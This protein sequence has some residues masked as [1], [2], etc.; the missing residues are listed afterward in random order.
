MTGII[1][2]F[3]TMTNGKRALIAG[4]LLTTGG[5]L[6]AF[7]LGV[8]GAAPVA[9][10]YGAVALSVSAALLAVMGGWST[11]WGARA[12]SAACIVGVVLSIAAFGIVLF[13]G[14]NEAQREADLKI[15]DDATRGD[16]S[17]NEVA[18]AR[19]R[20]LG[21][22]NAEVIL[23]SATDIARIDAALALATE[24]NNSATTD[25]NAKKVRAAAIAR[26]TADAEFA[27]KGW[28]GMVKDYLG[29]G[30]VKEKVEGLSARLSC[31]VKLDGWV[32][33][34]LVVLYI[35]GFFAGVVISWKPVVVE[36]IRIFTSGRDTQ[37]NQ[38]STFRSWMVPVGKIGLT[39]IM[40]LIVI[41]GPMYLFRNADECKAAI[42]DGLSAEAIDHLS[43][44]QEKARAARERIAERHAT[45]QQTTR[46]NKGEGQRK[47]A[48]VHETQIEGTVESA[49][50]P[51][52]CYAFGRGEDGNDLCVNLPKNEGLL[53][54]R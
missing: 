4:G 16:V 51:A 34:L 53:G 41:T 48:V 5:L 33:A 52:G 40:A 3:T 13:H 30:K 35:L 1:A 49:T 27:A 31:T 44:S 39:S 2:F 47:Q 42:T 21:G 25:E 50:I 38:Y 54:T 8:L 19:K 29:V 28:I 23:K 10:I 20:L 46:G 12:G 11:E 45:R 6:L 37:G 15:V 43:A 22:D 32:G 17:E 36:G 9:A 24:I 14:V 26:N 18:A 7:A